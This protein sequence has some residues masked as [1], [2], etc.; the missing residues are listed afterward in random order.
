VPAA[1]AAVAAAS[2]AAAAVIAVAIAASAV[3]KSRFQRNDFRGTELLS[4]LR[5][6]LF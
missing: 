6:F 1:A 4:G 2:A 3:T 5:P